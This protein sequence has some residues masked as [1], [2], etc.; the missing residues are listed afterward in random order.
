MPDNEWMNEIIATVYAC[1]KV[2]VIVAL[3]NKWSLCFHS[4]RRCW[5]NSLLSSMFLCC[6]S[7]S[8]RLRL[9]V[10]RLVRAYA[11]VVRITV[12]RNRYRSQPACQFS[13]GSC[14]C[15][16]SVPAAEFWCVQGSVVTHL[17]CGGVVAIIHT[18]E[19]VG[20]RMLKVCQYFTMLWII[21]PADAVI[22]GRTSC[23]K[24]IVN[25]C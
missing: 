7:M 3:W 25:E 9:K 5:P 15:E 22:D 19:C 24:N 21:D 2:G 23:S 13:V 20:E 11:A 17:R 10:P 4:R 18:A 1:D 14:C 6:V 8:T 12:S 16:I